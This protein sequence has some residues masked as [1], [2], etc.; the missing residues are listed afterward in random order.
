MLVRQGRIGRQ[1]QREG[2]SNV[3]TFEGEQFFAKRLGSAEA[4][5]T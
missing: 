2:H 3:E 1:R 4:S 5:G